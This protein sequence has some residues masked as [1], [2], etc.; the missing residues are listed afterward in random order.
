[1]PMH[2]LLY[3]V[4]WTSTKVGSVYVSNSTGS[5]SP[6][7]RK[8]SKVYYQGETR[9]LGVSNIQGYRSW[10]MAWEYLM[11]RHYRMIDTFYTGLAFPKNCRENTETLGT[12]NWNKFRNK[13]GGKLNYHC[14][15]IEDKEDLGKV[16]AL[17]D[18]F[19]SVYPMNIV[20][21]KNAW[22]TDELNKL[23]KHTRSKLRALLR[24]NVPANWDSYYEARCRYKKAVRSVKVDSWRI[25]YE[26]IDKIPDLSKVR[27]MLAKDRDAIEKILKLSPGDQSRIPEKALGIL[28]NTHF[29][30]A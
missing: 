14:F 24:N 18:T 29:P 28:L 17:L 25:F 26:S 7:Q 2:I 6:K 4:V 5:T 12:Q 19:I 30:G 21:G 22:W 20:Q 3:G 9:G 15:R 11:S 13:L 10:S 23:R 27:K 8:S 1:M 16:A